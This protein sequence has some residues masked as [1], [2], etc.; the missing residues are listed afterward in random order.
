MKINYR[1]NNLLAAAALAL[2]VNQATAATFTWDGS[3]S[4]FWN[5][6]ANWEGGGAPASANTTDIIIKGTANVGPMYPGNVSYTIKSL[7]FDASNDADTTFSMQNGGNAGQGSRNLTFSSASGNATLTVESGSTGNKTIDRLGTTAATITLTSSLDV[8]HNGSG[9]LTLGKALNTIVTGGG[10]IN[11]SGT[12]T[13]SLPAANNYAGATLLNDGT[14]S[15]T[16]SLTGGTAITVANAAILTQSAAGAISGASSLTH[17]SSATSTLSGVNT[18]SGPTVVNSGKLLVHGSLSSAGL[19]TVKLG[20]TFGGVGSA[21]DVTVEDLAFLSPG[22]P[23]F[24]ENQLT[25][26]RLALVADS[27]LLFDLADPIPSGVYTLPFY[28]DHIAV[29]GNLTLAGKLRVNPRPGFDAAPDNRWMLMS[30]A[31]GSGVFKDNH[32][33]LD[34]ANSPGLPTPPEGYRYVIDTAEPGYVFLTVAVPEPAT[35]T[36]LTFGLLLLGRA[37]RRRR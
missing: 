20:A 13:L 29:Q 3:D 14:I 21:G 16:G 24:S 23:D 26:N 34:V 28:S 7:T 27:I 2:L 37:V 4:Q 31:V 32:L 6:A 33:E 15:L 22:K 17:N 35:G 5:N 8:I 1:R 9:T 30:Y 19:V 10:G 36:L 11:K 12:G 18:Y 25:L